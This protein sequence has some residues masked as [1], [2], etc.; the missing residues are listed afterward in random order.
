[1][2]GLINQ[3]HKNVMFCCV[4]P[5]KLALNLNSTKNHT[6]DAEKQCLV[7][8]K[9]SLCIKSTFLVRKTPIFRNRH[10]KIDK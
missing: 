1:M 6:L 2:D 3:K 4:L 7:V 8:M 9:L 5:L 10:T